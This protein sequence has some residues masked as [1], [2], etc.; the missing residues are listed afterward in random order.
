MSIMVLHHIRAVDQKGVFLTSFKDIFLQF[1]RRLEPTIEEGQ[2][3]LVELSESTV[4][5]SM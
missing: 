4:V 2:V 5:L 1:I 3:K